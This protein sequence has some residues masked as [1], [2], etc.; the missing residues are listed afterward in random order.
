MTETVFVPL[1]VLEVD[2]SE[3]A[4]G[5]LA[6]SRRWSWADFPLLAWCLVRELDGQVGVQAHDECSHVWELKVHQHSYHLCLHSD[7][8]A[9]LEARTP[10]ARVRLDEI[11]AAL[12][13]WANQK[14]EGLRGKRVPRPRGLPGAAA[15]EPLGESAARKRFLLTR[16]VFGLGLGSGLAW[17]LASAISG[18]HM[19]WPYMLLLAFGLFPLIG[20]VWATWL[21]RQGRR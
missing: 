21:W 8:L 12:M 13:V 17:L 15:T 6:L 2:T 4:Q 9:L 7:G 14:E 1:E 19:P 5:H 16:G 18:S 10:A 20:Y 3:V 11:Q